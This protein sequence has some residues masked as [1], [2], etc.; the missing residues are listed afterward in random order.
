M[1]DAPPNPGSLP[2]SPPES[3]L[4]PAADTVL[5]VLQDPVGAAPCLQ[6]AAAA[7]RAL[8]QPEVRALHVRC[9]PAAT[10][11]ASEEVLPEE[12]R[13]ALAAKAD[14]DAAAIHAAF[15]AWRSP[16]LPSRWEQVDGVPAEIVAARATAALVVMMSLP[17]AHAPLT[18]RAALDAALFSPG[19]PVLVVPTG[20]TDGFGRHLAVGWRDTPSTRQALRTAR[21]WLSR[22]ESV[23]VISVGPDA[24]AWPDP[25]LIGAPAARVSFRA[26]DPNGR[27]EG[28]SLLSA[29]AEVGADGL[30]MGAYRRSQVMEWI[31]GGVTRYCLHA[32]TIPLLMVH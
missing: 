10:L 2:G 29:V 16:S 25:G 12:R 5:A 6:V 8:A 4:G 15:L 31:L 24:P 21:P 26:I 7:A 14:T 23:T 17:R 3:P 22:A 18:D 11:M 20:W 32:A 30:V 19:R 27:G 13:Q 28:E 9:D 1:T